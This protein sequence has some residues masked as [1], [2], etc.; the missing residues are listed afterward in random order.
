LHEVRNRFE[1][2]YD[3]EPAELSV[4]VSGLG[5]MDD[6]EPAL[7]NEASERDRAINTAAAT[8]VFDRIHDAEANWVTPARDLIHAG[9]WSGDAATEFHNSIIEPFRRGG[10]GTDGVHED[11]RDGRAG[12][13]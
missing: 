13:S 10:R 5:G 8:T 6:A 1:A 12:V 2:Y 4:I 9:N 11:P 7:D 3:L